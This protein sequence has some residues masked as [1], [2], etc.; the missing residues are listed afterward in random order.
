MTRR[1][2]RFLAQLG[3]K[4]VQAKIVKTAPRPKSFAQRRAKLQTFRARFISSFVSQTAPSYVDI[5]KPANKSVS[6]NVY[7]VFAGII[8]IPA[9]QQWSFY[10]YQTSHNGRN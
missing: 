6:L 3:K 1:R 8:N 9:Y 2:R 10:I 4:S 7:F 5:G